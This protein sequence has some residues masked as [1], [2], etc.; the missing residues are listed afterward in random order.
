MGRF[1]HSDHLT[2]A[3]DFLMFAWLSLEYWDQCGGRR[4]LF[5]CFC[6]FLWSTVSDAS[7]HHD[8]EGVATEPLTSWQPA[9]RKGRDRKGPE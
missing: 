6:C 5:L 2:L 4:G 7:V 8:G 9:K 3:T 1:S